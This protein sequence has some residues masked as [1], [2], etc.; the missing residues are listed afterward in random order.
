MNQKILDKDDKQI[1]SVVGACCQLGLCCPCCGDVVFD[2]TTPQMPKYAKSPPAIK[3]GEVRKVFNGC[4]ELM[5]QA[6][7]FRITFPEKIS[8]E[9]KDLIFASCMLIDLEYFEK[10]EKN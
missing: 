6:N 2:I 10:K 3:V 7:A 1:Y 5:A 4:A 9:H 8:L